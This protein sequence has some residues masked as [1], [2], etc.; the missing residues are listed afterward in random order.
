VQ[1]GTGGGW[2]VKSWAPSVSPTQGHYV[3]NEVC[4][5]EDVNTVQSAE[6]VREQGGEERRLETTAQGGAS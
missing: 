1:D 5:C 3:I 6:G 2:S 4:L